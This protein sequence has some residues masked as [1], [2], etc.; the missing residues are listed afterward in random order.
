MSDRQPE[1]RRRVTLEDLLRLKRAER[2][3]QEFWTEFHEEL[4]QRQLAAL[5]ER[6][7]WWREAVFFPH[8]RGLRLPL[9]AAAVLALTLLSIHRHA[10]S[11]SVEP[12]ENGTPPGEPVAAAVATLPARTE[13]VAMTGPAST[14]APAPL[15]AAVSRQEE[16]AA[17]AAGT[18]AATSGEGAGIIPWLGDIALDRLAAVETSTLGRP[19]AVGLSSVSVM[20]EPGLAASAAPALSFEERAMP[21]MRRRSTADVLPTAAA[22]AAPHRARLLAVLD[23]ARASILPEPSAPEHVRRSATRYLMQDG[24]D[25]AMS[26]LDAERVGLSLVRF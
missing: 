18:T 17:P 6:K 20:A 4:R 23:T 24:G 22:A 26:R 19:T 9:G 13:L 5:V 21:E 15:P 2:P 1:F 7:S 14:R 3:P 10:P 12:R 16:H 8:V 25:R 11:V